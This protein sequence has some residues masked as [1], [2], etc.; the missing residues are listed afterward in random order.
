MIHLQTADT[1]RTA[2]ALQQFNDHKGAG[3]LVSIVTYLA[4][5]LI[6]SLCTRTRLVS[7]M[8]PLPGSE[9]PGGGGVTE[10]FLSFPGY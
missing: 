1:Q 7:R 2:P 3:L 4:V 10:Q 9:L 8:D 6:Q 5:A